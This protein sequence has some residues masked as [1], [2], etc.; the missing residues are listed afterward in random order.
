M[1]YPFGLAPWN[2]DPGPCPVDDTP[3]TACTPE[4]V[5]ARKRGSLTVPIKRPRALE[6]ERVIFTT[7]EYKRNN[8]GR[9]IAR[10]ASR[11]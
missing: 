2:R 7:K 4:S 1:W 6:P 10:H 3:H 9:R 5:A 8:H 11:D